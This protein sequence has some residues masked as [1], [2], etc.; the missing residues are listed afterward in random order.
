MTVTMRLEERP[1]EA[2]AVRDLRVELPAYK[3]VLAVAPTG[4]GKTVI[5]TLLLA[6]EKRWRRVLWLAHRAELVGQARESLF[7]LGVPCGVRCASYEAL[8]PDHVDREA[9]VQVGSVQTVSRQEVFDVDLIVVDEAHRA[10]ADSYQAI[11]R[12]RPRAEV[13]GLTAT[14]LRMDGRELGDFFQSLLVLAKP[15]EL[16]AEGYLAEPVTYAAGPETRALLAQR[17]RSV[18]VK[19]G[20]F[21]L[22]ALGRA[23]NTTD[24]VGD[25]VSETRRLAPGVPKVVFAATVAHSREI[26]ERFSG[27]G[28]RAA[29]ID[30]D[31]PTDDRSRALAMLASG[32]LEVVCNV[33]ILTEGWDLPVLGAVVVARPTWS[34]GR[35]MQMVGRVQR[36][37]SG[38]PKLVLDHGGNADRLQHFPGE[39]VDWKLARGSRKLKR[40]A[41]PSVRLCVACC[42]VLRETCEVCLHCGT[43]QPR[44]TKRLVEEHEAELVELDRAR[45]EALRRGVRQRAEEV[46]RRVGAPASWVD[47][48]VEAVVLRGGR[49]R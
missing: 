25:V 29:H 11:A 21:Q 26:A 22:D 39:D 33:E 28:V 4:A 43:A 1:Y 36:P 24:L 15:S 13:L 31:T 5:A 8:H 17:L 34:L 2:K 40:R 35:F 16:Y 6:V 23:V 32:E 44:S 7:S 14:P 30:A 49:G 19:G 42:A 3:R 41:P 46:A 45:I 48:V 37:G 12:L 38:P 9:R 27:V 18:R 20:D 10:M 47:T